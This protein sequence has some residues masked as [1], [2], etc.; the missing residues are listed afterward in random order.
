MVTRNTRQEDIA[1][2][3]MLQD[4]EQ[5]IRALWKR[6]VLEQNI[7]NNR[8]R[9]NIIWRYAFT[10]AVTE[11]T[12]LSY[13]TIGSIIN[14]DHSTVVHTRK[15]HET[16]MYDQLYKQVYFTML[17]E[18]TSLVKKYQDSIQ[19]LIINRKQDYGGA[20]TL[21]SMVN[22][23]ERRI[24]AMERNYVNKLESYEQEIKILRKHLKQATNRAELLNKEAMRLK[25]LL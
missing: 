19:A 12:S 18:M 13:M 25:N 5:M 4:Q 3:H 9:K 24:E 11:T 14:K 23:Y 17:D 16:N 15:Q 7:K 22:M 10:M 21:N 20:A 2:L 6:I 8:F 1:K